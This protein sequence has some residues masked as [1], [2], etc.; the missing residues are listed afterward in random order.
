MAA[1][2]DNESGKTTKTS[3]TS[4]TATTSGT[5]RTSKTAK[6]SS[7][8]GGSGRSGSGAPRAAAKPRMKAAQIAEAAGR[9]L[10]ELAGKEVEG[11]TG[12]ERTDDGWT[13]HVE[14]L[15]LRRIPNTTDV[16]A[17]YEVTLDSDGDLEGYRRRDRYV[18]GSAEGNA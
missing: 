9:Q 14:V 7:S 17:S 10:A 12:L 1:D 15:E 11:V 18:R 3:K 6:T 2:D 16:L 5:S 8:R 13:V 4:K